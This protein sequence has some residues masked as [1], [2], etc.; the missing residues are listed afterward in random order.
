MS[1]VK[2]STAIIRALDEKIENSAQ[3]SAT[4][5]KKLIAIRARMN[6]SR[7]V[8]FVDEA[9]IDAKVFRNIY[10]S[11]KASKFL[12]TVAT[13]EFANVEQNVVAA[14]K[15]IALCVKNDTTT[16][17]KAQLRASLCRAMLDK[18]S[19]AER[20]VTY[21]RQNSVD[22]A[23]VDTQ[24]SQLVLFLTSL[25]LLAQHS[26]AKNV[27]QICNSDLLKSATERFAQDVV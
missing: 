6:D 12:F 10:A 3:N 16:V 9:K 17:T 23:T 8:K 2:S 11:D 15:T 26:S 13:N 24:T 4:N 7:V 14:I 1:K 25:K 19:D 21:T 5:Q 27:Y 20:A 18:L 22:A